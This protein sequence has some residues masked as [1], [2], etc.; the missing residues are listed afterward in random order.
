MIPSIRTTRTVVLGLVLGAAGTLPACVVASAGPD[1]SGTVYVLGHLDAK[2]SGTPQDVVKASE[3]VFKDQDMH[4]VS[5]D[6]TGLDG[7]VVARTALETRIEV[8]VERQDDSTSKLSIRVGTFGDQKLS[9]EL[10]EKIKARL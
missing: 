2:V 10:F 6:A 7:K 4:I 5:S 3:K 9:R 1:A 8:T